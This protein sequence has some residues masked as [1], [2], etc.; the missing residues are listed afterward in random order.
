MTREFDDLESSI[1]IP[2]PSLFLLTNDALITNADPNTYWIVESKDISSQIPIIKGSNVI[3]YH[4]ILVQHFI[5]FSESIAAVQK[6]LL[7]RKSD[8]FSSNEYYIL[9]VNNRLPFSEIRSS[10][11]QLSDI[12]MVEENAIL[13]FSKVYYE[14]LKQDTQIEL[15]GSSLLKYLMPL[16]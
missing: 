16:Y 2:R 11:F 1:F 3:F 9:T 8:N 6:V 14:K 10:K 12:N 4:E 5:E 7:W 15:E 13:F